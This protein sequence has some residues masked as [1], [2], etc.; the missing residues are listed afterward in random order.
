[1]FQG[2]A[3]LNRIRMCP[4]CRVIDMAKAGDPAL[5][6]GGT[7]PVTRRRRTIICAKRADE[8]CGKPNGRGNGDGRH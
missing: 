5:G 7:R 8:E 6:E 4:D 3:A 2:E 1:M